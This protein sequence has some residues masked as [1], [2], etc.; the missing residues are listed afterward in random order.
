LTLKHNLIT[1]TG[2]KLVFLY[3]PVKDLQ[4][5]LAFYRDEL[6]WDEAWREGD[7]T[8]AMQIPGSEVQVMLDGTDA[9]SPHG[10][11]GF[12][13]VEDVDRFLAD[14]GDRVNVMEAPVDLAPIRYASF[15]D[16]SGNLF[17]IFHNLPE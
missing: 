7:S 9:D 5:A 2:M 14:H 15:T 17:R 6:G 1:L 4:A 12:Y 8:I 13:E 16:P 11:S 10:A 3:H